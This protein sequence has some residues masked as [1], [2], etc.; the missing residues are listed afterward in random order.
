[1]IELCPSCG[2]GNSYHHA[3]CPHHRTV[4]KERRT[5]ELARKW[6]ER[7]REMAFERRLSAVCRG[8]T[9]EGG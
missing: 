9:K 2:W 7:L 3:K 5:M 6:Q 4:A 8:D 1:M